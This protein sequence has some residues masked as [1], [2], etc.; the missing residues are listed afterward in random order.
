MYQVGTRSVL[1]NSFSEEVEGQKRA[2]YDSEST[3]RVNNRW[4]FTQENTCNLA[5]V[6]GGELS[7]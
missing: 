7:S 1:L 2:A 4:M 3:A 5:A 6:A